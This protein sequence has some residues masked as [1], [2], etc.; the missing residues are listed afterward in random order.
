MWIIQEISRTWSHLHNVVASS[1]NE[2]INPLAEL[3][4]QLVKMERTRDGQLAEMQGESL[5]SSVQI[6]L[7][8]DEITNRCLSIAD[9]EQKLVALSLS[10]IKTINLDVTCTDGDGLSRGQFFEVLD[11]GGI[12]DVIGLYGLEVAEQL[13]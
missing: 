3:H 11:F 6:S 7:L 9:L 8:Q 13:V 4:A 12:L 10:N 2:E 5:H 1:C